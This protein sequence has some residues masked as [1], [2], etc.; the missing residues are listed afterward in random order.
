VGF[1]AIVVIALF[2]LSPMASAGSSPTSNG[3]AVAAP[4]A[5]PAAVA[6]AVH[7]FP[8]PI[9]HVF[10]VVLENAGRTG[11][12]ANGPFEK[13]LQSK[14]A[15]G[16][17]YYAICHPSA[18]NYLALTSGAT[19]QCGSDGYKTYSTENLGHLAQT[20][21]LSWAGFD[22]SMPKP[23][24]TSN[25]GLYAVR[26]NPVVYYSDIAGNSAVCK[27][28]DVNFTAWNSDVAKGTIPAL[29]IISPNLNDDGHDTNV[30]TADK[31]LSGWLSPLVNDSWFNSS[32]FFITYDESEGTNSSAGYNG[33]A[34]GKVY[35]VAVSPYAK[36]GFDLTMDASH[37][38]LL[39]TMEWLLGV[40]STGHND[41]SSKFPALKQMFSFPPGTVL[42]P[43]T[44]TSLKATATAT[45]TSGTAPL[46]VSFKGSA[47]GGSTPYTYS[48]N[49][50]GTTT[51][52]SQNPSHVYQ[53]AGSYQATLTVKD[54]KGS[55][56]TAKL[57]I[58]A[59]KSSVNGIAASLTTG[60]SIGTTPGTF[61][62]LDAVTNTG[63]GLTTDGTVKSF[64]SNTPFKWV[65]LGVDA[66][67]C[68]AST[69]KNYA[70]DGSVTTGCG[71]YLT[72][73]KTWCDAQTPHCHM[74]L[75]LPGENNNSGEDAAIAKY[76]VNTVGLQPD[77][78]VIG[79]EPMNWNHY[80]IAWSNW[81]VTDASKA[82]PLAYAI[83]VK[84]GIAAVKKVD[85]AAKFIGVEAAC[86][87]NSVWFQDVAKIDGSSI[88]AIAYHQYPSNGLTTMTTAQLYE[89]LN[90]NKNLTSSYA[91]VRADITGQC[92]GCSTMPIFLN[93][94]NAG[95][96]WTPSNLGGTYSNAVF[97]ASSV[98]QALR[99][100]IPQFTTY[101]LQTSSTG[102]YGY[103]MI[104]GS[105]TIGP[106]GLLF[107][108]LLDHL[109]IGSVYSTAVK[110]SILGVWSVMT[111]NGTKASLLVVNSNLSNAIALSLGTVFPTGISASV[112]TW[113]PS[114]SAPKE[115]TATIATSYSIPSQG[116]LLITVSSYTGKIGAL[117]IGHAVALSGPAV[118]LHTPSP[119][120]LRVVGAPPVGP[121]VTGRVPIAV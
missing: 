31:W 64:L 27:A 43:L 42:A 68:N 55:T 36:K 35:F 102:T 14:Y 47:S 53:Y 121:L 84:N 29:G 82:T 104:D 18:P 37:Y 3:P 51:S 9:H 113:D 40:G 107:S 93:E 67:S 19:H 111:Q 118:A 34:G 95:P 56:S 81:D 8:T 105:N 49:F 116:M 54:S 21:G 46:T 20:A 115:S 48:W 112:Y 109:T 73:L 99:A 76:I 25:S 6:P 97:L 90:S 41:S 69:G 80:G 71:A 106:T 117:P 75:T 44:T 120:T 98:T 52:S 65:R 72:S 62:S 66:D 103:S 92:T 60:S 38:N 2:F 28:H 87:C 86:S 108:D 70:D 57:T 50:G 59:K 33:T 32:V 30:A 11:V 96:G 26:H 74:I 119:A 83:D 24:D 78:W 85:P 79:N 89:L 63:S 12:L 45:P 100:K 4:G 77:Y 39:A 10:L 22:E 61:W 88:A 58:T 16:S 91:T 7:T 17:N 114:L 15:Y 101:D 1:G 13:A 94:Y 5:A 23:C 110:T